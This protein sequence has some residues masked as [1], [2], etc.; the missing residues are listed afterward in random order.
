MITTALEKAIE[1]SGIN[2]IIH[3][4]IV[5]HVKDLP[6]ASQLHKLRQ[7]VLTKDIEKIKEFLGSRRE[8]KKARKSWLLEIKE[9]ALEAFN[10]WIR[11]Y[12]I[13]PISTSEIRDLKICL[14][15][16]GIT[17]RFPDT[18]MTGEAGQT[19]QLK[20]T[21][22]RKVLLAFIDELLLRHSGLGYRIFSRE[23]KEH[24]EVE[25]HDPI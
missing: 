10:D 17:I 23:G 8:K 9:E 2:K 13:E 25:C 1:V 12:L 21:I 11:K 19:D 5:P 18:L 15:H 22:I 7:S 16:L 14:S 4:L 24:C 20:F 6:S 3:N